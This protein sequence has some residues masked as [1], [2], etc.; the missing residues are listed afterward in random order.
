MIYN[1]R[2]AKKLF[3]KEIRETFASAFAVWGF[4]KKEVL[5]TRRD[6]QKGIIRGIMIKVLRDKTD[7]SCLE[8]ARVFNRDDS[9]VY[10]HCKKHDGR[11]ET[12]REYKEN[13]VRYL[14]IFETRVKGA[15]L[16]TPVTRYEVSTPTVILGRQDIVPNQLK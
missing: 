11:L 14:K 12:D 5:G 7:L 3:K 13:Y 15:A 8:L 6:K 16:D 1:L 9:C 2:P 10:Y 4:D